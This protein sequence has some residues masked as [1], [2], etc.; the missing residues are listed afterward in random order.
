[1]AS[2]TWTFEDRRLPE[3]FFRYRA[4]NFPES[5]N[6][7]ENARWREHCRETLKGKAGPDWEGFSKQLNEERA[8]EGLS[9]TQIAALD[10]LEQYTREL[11]AELAD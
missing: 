9:V 6:P 8:R 7:D 10:D 4:R 1:L 11:R 5:L 2:H 3:V